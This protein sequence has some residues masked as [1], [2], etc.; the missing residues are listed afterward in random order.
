MV[1]GLQPAAHSPQHTA[2]SLQPTA[3]STQHTARTHSATLF[4]KDHARRVEA[5]VDDDDDWCSCACCRSQS[6]CCCCCCRCCCCYSCY[7]FPY[8]GPVYHTRDRFPYQGHRLPH[9]LHTR[10]RYPTPGTSIPSQ[11]PSPHTVCQLHS[12]T[13]RPIF[14]QRG[15]Y[16]LTYLRLKASHIWPPRRQMRSATL[17][18]EDIN[19]SPTY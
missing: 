18:G 14:A 7:Y 13:S 1:Y 8:P 11:G 5:E 16:Y 4:A 12:G 19:E 6:C 10:D 17:R 15:R 3:H 2:H 9:T